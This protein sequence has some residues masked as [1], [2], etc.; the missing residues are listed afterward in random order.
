VLAAGVDLDEFYDRWGP[1]EGHLSRFEATVFE[2][3]VDGVEH[4]P[5][6][7]LRPEVDWAAWRADPGYHAVRLDLCLLSSDHLE[8]DDD[9]LLEC[10]AKLQQWA[11]RADD[12]ALREAVS[13]CLAGRSGA[14]PSD[15]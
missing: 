13:R 2:D 8:V 3:L 4:V 10:R 14:D 12:I 6:R 7:L 1:L 5:G 11:V 9:R 15:R